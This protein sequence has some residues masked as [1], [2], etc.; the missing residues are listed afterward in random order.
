MGKSKRMKRLFLCSY[1]ANVAGVFEQFAVDQNLEKEVLFVPTAANL[2]DEKNYVDEAEAVFQQMGYSVEILDIA[3]TNQY[4]AEEKIRQVQLLYVSSGNTFYLLQELNKKN[5]CPLIRDR[6]KAG[7]VYIGESAGAIIAGENID[8]NQLLTSD[9]CMASSKNGYALEVISY[10]I[11][12]QYEESSF[13]E[14]EQKILE[15]YGKALNALPLTNDQAAIFIDNE[16]PLLK[17]LFVNCSGLMSAKIWREP[18][19]FSP[20]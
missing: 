6:I 19:W 16:M 18:N 15:H 14:H 9:N 13:S 4:L 3:K 8:Y 12:S 5:L 10:Y 2:A 17:R 1:F 7:M 11:L 20:F